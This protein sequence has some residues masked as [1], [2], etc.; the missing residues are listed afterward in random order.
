MRRI[1]VWLKTSTLSLFILAVPAGSF[2]DPSLGSARQHSIDRSGVSG[3][4][5]FLD[6][7][8]PDKGLIMSGSATGLD[9]E[10]AYL[11]LV[12]DQGSAP[13]GP[14]ACE[15][16]GPALNGAQ[17]FVGVWT[18]HEDGTGTLFAVK[19]GSRY[20]RLDQI[21]AVSIRDGSRA[22]QACGRVHDRP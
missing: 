14:S 12:Y 16:T 20:A 19:T 7:G 1:P 5:L 6:T 10:Q 9:P 21:G 17:M 11:T 13:S 4:I 22:L 3:R 8:D 18:V 15:P 2:A